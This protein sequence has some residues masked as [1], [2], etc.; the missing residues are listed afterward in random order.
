MLDLEFAAESKSAFR[1]GWKLLRACLN[2]VLSSGCGPSSSSPPCGSRHPYHTGQSLQWHHLL[3]TH[4]GVCMEGVC[5]RGVSGQ[6]ID[7]CWVSVKE[8]FQKLPN[9]CPMTDLIEK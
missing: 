4:L 6:K 5:D 3:C 9:F 8:I 7:V 2:C 1:V